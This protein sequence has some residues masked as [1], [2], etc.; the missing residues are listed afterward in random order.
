MTSEIAALCPD[1]PEPV[2]RDLLPLVKGNIRHIDEIR[3]FDRELKSA[4]LEQFGANV[5]REAY[6][7]L[8]GR[9]VTRSAILHWPERKLE[10]SGS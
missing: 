1:M 10:V 6:P 8:A 9:M 5:I 7:E 3:Q 2:Q 4:F